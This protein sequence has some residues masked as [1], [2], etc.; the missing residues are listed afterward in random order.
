VPTRIG[1]LWATMH[2]QGYRGKGTLCH[3][4]GLAGEVA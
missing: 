4:P 1:N 3:V 2:A